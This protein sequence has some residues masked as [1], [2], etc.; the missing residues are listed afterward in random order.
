M[1]VASGEAE[2]VGYRKPP[3]RHRFQKGTSGNPK[4][5]PKSAKN[6]VPVSHTLEFGTQPA[7]QMFMEEVYRPVT[8]RE[9]DVTI[10]LPA[11]QAVFRSMSVKAVKG[12]RFAQRLIAE[13]VQGIES[14]DRELRTEY[15]KTM[16][17]YKVDA[18]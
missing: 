8:L 14:A 18:E 6:K 13:L 10:Q 16:M 17:E 11:I 1:T 2:E 4:G 15:M 3:A 9:G 7:N 12:D 5:R